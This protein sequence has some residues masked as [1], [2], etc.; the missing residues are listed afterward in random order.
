MKVV[1]GA[2]ADLPEVGADFD[3]HDWPMV[4]LTEPAAQ[5]PAGMRAVYRATLPIT[6]ERL[7]AGVAITFG[8]IDDRGTLYVNGHK[9]GSADDWSHP[10]TFDITQYLHEGNNSIAVWV[11]NDYGDGGLYKGCDVDP[12]GRAL[13]NVQVSPATSL[14]GGA[15]D[16]DQQRR[17]LVHYT[18]EFQLPR[19][20]STLPVTWKLHLDADANAFMTLNGHLLGRYWAVGPQRDIWLPECW[21]NFGP[22]EMNVVELQARPTADAPVG[23]IIKLAEVRPY[24][25]PTNAASNTP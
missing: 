18:M 3:D 13:G 10:W 12:V 1:T 14:A 16:G 5:T 11:Q 6:K 7:A 4:V 19:M 22:N 24:V 2:P 20:S 9:A 21:L 25:Q 23:K 8:T 15:I 17:L